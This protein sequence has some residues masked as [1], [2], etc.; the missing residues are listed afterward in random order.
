MG[1]K[2]YANQGFWVN[3]GTP[4]NFF[5]ICTDILLDKPSILAEE[6]LLCQGCLRGQN[7]PRK[8]SF[9]LLLPSKKISNRQ[10]G[11]QKIAQRN[12]KTGVQKK[13]QKFSMGKKLYANQGFWVNEGYP[14]EFFQNLHRHTPWQA[15][16]FGWRNPAVARMSKGSKPPRKISFSTFTPSKKISNRQ[17]GYQKI[18]QRNPKTVVQKKFQK[19]SMGKKLYANQG[20]LGQWGYPWEFFQNLHRHTPW[21]AEHFGWRNPAVHGCLRGQNPLEKLVFDFYSLKKKFK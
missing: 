14:W 15:E 6:T 10:M 11:Y 8:I 19:F 7:P 12:P 5:K 13:Y 3:E 4:G 21:Q 20:F 2:L 9:R 1:K 17:M 18:A 16:H